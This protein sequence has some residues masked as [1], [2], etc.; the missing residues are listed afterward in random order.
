MR[1]QA[2]SRGPPGARLS[3]FGGKRDTGPGRRAP[4]GGTG[5]KAKGFARP[6]TGDPT[7]L[8]RPNPTG[9]PDARA[10]HP[11]A[12]AGSAGASGAGRGGLRVG[13]GEAS[14]A[15]RGWGRGRRSRGKGSPGLE[16]GGELP[17]GDTTKALGGRAQTEEGGMKCW[18]LRWER[19]PAEL[20]RAAGKACG[21]RESEGLRGASKEVPGTRG[22]R[23]AP[24]A[25]GGAPGSGRGDFLGQLELGT[26]CH[27]P[28]VTW[29]KAGESLDVNPGRS[30]F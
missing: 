6:P 3:G 8:G 18:E 4:G 27:L 25:G 2:R 26:V 17:G 10:P 30:C 29:L 16:V 28:K 24:R 9:R 1:S 23:A 19:S 14:R 11:R 7:A 21:A 5:D 15:A 22:G 13:E 20:P 12:W